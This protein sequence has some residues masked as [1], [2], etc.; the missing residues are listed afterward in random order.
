[1]IPSILNSIK[2]NLGI[3]PEYTAFDADILMFIN[4]V[5][6]T[7]NQLG[8][9]PV[10][11]FLIEDA[12]EEWDAFLGTDPRLNDV[13]TYMSLRVRMLFDPPQTSYFQESMK[14]QIKEHEWRLNARREE[15]EWTD[16]NVL[17]P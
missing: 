15:T 2:K 1:M 10:E 11:G 3:A 7:L 6:S 14:E 12:T 8:V 17:V 16:P 4:G 5:F 13:K 9:G